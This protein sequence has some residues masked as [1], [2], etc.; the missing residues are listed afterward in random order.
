CCFG[1]R[2]GLVRGLGVP[3]A[4]CFSEWSAIIPLL[5]QLHADDEPGIV[6]LA[7]QNRSQ[8]G[9]LDLY[10]LVL[11]RLQPMRGELGHALEVEADSF[12]HPPH[13][14]PQGRLACESRPARVRYGRS[15]PTGA[16]PATSPPDPSTRRPPQRRPVSCGLTRGRDGCRRS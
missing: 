8:G 1:P 3:P 12:S 6:L 4:C 7:T 16:R 9:N 5:H 13:P 2:M 15:P 10:V 14:F 11:H